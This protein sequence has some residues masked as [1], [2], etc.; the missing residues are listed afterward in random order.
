MRLMPCRIL[1]VTWD[2]P[3]VSY[4]ETLFIPIFERLLGDGVQFDV[5]Q[6]RWGNPTQAARIATRCR[7]SGIGYRALT[8]RRWPPAIGAFATALLGASQVRRA[9]RHFRADLL[10]PRSVMPALAVLAAGG[11]Q[12][13]PIIFDADGLEADERADFQGLSRAS[14]IYRLLRA[15]ER[16]GVRQADSVLVRTADAATILSERASVGLD[17]FHVVT[18]GRDVGLFSEG[19]AE[20]RAAVRSELNVE[21]DAPLLIYAGSVG[22]KYRIGRLADFA[23]VFLE[24]RP[25]TRLLVLSGSPED[26][27]RELTRANPQLLEAATIMS[28][29][30]EKVPRYIRAADVGFALPAVTFSTR[31]VVATKVAEY[32]LC[33]V[34]VIGTGAVGDNRAALEAGIFFDED[35]GPDA[36]A[37]WVLGSVLTQRDRFRASAREI[38][39]ESF[40]LDRA[41]SDYLKAIAAACA[42]R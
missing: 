23:R 34:P 13:R 1:F 5:L 12:L 6:F 25:D 29:E 40:S 28:V 37:D 2:G 21:P 14:P 30:P 33:G 11:R 26:A 7:E 32:L 36:A 17:R 35:G 19:T 27:R 4:L 8:I 16:Q 10:M 39:I 3:Q 24:R 20:E 9:V 42:S 38:G 41:G 15:V 22:P 31:A 18:N